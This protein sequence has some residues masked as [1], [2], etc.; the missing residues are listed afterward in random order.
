[1][2]GGH[3]DDILFGGF[4]EDYINGGPG[5]DELYGWFGDDIL[6]GGPGADYFDCGDGQDLIVDFN[7]LQGDTHADNC[8]DIREQL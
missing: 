3:G 4:D 8:E 5:N 6:E 7:P 1:L 2:Y